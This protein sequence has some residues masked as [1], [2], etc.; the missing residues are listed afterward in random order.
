MQASP[1]FNAPVRAGRSRT[2]R[3]LII[4]IVAVASML[5]AVTYRYVTVGQYVMSTDNAYVRADSTIIAPRISGYISEVLV[6]D[7]EEVKAGRVLARIDDRDL[8]IA[9][10]QVRANVAAAQA[11]L[12]SRQFTLD[13]QETIIAAAC[14]TVDIDRANATFAEQD[15]RRYS[16]LAASSS[17]SIQNAQQ[18]AARHAVARATLERDSAALTTARRHVDLLRAEVEQ[19][20]AALAQARAIERQAAL[21]LSYTAI[22]A[23]VGGV[24]GN[25]TLRVGQYVQAGTQLMAVVPLDDI[26]V[27]ANFKETQ[28]RNVRPG[29][30]AGIEVDMLSG[31]AFHGHVESIAPASGQEFALLP[32]DNATGNFT[33]IVQRIPVRIRI[34]DLA[35]HGG[36]LRPGMSVEASVNT[37]DGS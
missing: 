3:K 29:Q 26:Y 8:Q 1:T 31:V 12:A 2:A 19:T 32:P 17:G 24:V 37:K 27:V 4:G 7:N 25:R 23:P 11:T 13:T 10:D 16:T 35:G 34:D 21:N 30:P 33:K 15:D 36:T 20:Q 28:L 18:A 6:G 22:L 5:T 9:L 14:A